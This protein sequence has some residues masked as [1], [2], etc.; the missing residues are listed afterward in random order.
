MRL[1]VALGLSCLCA[2]TLC[3]G[4]AL[5]ELQWNLMPAT[6]SMARP[7]YDLH[8]V[9]MIIISVIFVGVF[10][11]MLYAILRHR[12]SLGHEAEHFHETTTVEIMW[13]IV[14]L[15]II[16]GMAWPATRTLLEIRD[17]P[18]A[19]ITIKLTRYQMKWG[20]EYL[21]DDV[22]FY[23]TLAAPRA[24]IDDTPE[25]GD[26]S[27]PEVDQPMVIPVGR[28]VRVLVTSSDAS[29]ASALEFGR[30][31]DSV[32]GVVRDVWFRVDTIGTYRVRCAQSCGSDDD[33]T[34][35]LVKVVSGDEYDDWLALQKASPGAG[36]FDQIRAHPVAGPGAI[37]A[38]G[39]DKYAHG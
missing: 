16:I 5:A 27:L 25:S 23:S 34:S 37:G 33:F 29:P 4:R 15:L 28:K 9:V 39:G 22:N 11:F 7:L 13:T 14:P 17:A 30:E 19:D 24:N 10:G 31:Q 2:A 21:G 26:S 8:F 38:L 1:A 3:S 20:Y 6:T 35:I 12:K 18:I 32:S 36:F